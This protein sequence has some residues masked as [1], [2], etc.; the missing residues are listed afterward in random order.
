[1][2]RRFSSASDRQGFDHRNA[3]VSDTT[4]GT[5]VR[6]NNPGNWMDKDLQNTERRRN[7]LLE[8]VL[9][10][11]AESE[12]LPAENKALHYR[13]DTSPISRAALQQRK[14]ELTEELAQ[15]KETHAT[16]IGTLQDEKNNLHKKLDH[17]QKKHQ[18]AVRTINAHTTRS[19]TFQDEK[20]SLQKELAQA[21]EE[22][23]QAADSFIR[24]L[25]YQKEDFEKY[26]AQVKEDCRQAVNT[27][28]IQI[29]TLEKQHEGDIQELEV[30]AS[31]LSKLH[32]ALNEPQT[33]GKEEGRPTVEVAKLE[34]Q[35]ADAYNAHQL[36][37]QSYT[38][39]I[40]LLEEMNQ[41]LLDKATPLS[42]SDRKRPRPADITEVQEID[43]LARFS[44]SS[45][46]EVQALIPGSTTPV[47]QSQLPKE[48]VSEIKEWVTKLD[49]LGSKK[50]Q[51]T[52]LKPNHEDSGTCLVQQFKHNTC[53]WIEP[54][55]ACHECLISGSPCIVIKDNRP[56]LLPL[57]E[58]WGRN[59]SPSDP[60]YWIQ[61]TWP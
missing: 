6:N 19:N 46:V 11:D 39:R 51:F 21:R 47:P 22:Y 13:I 9:I 60:G 34:Q 15:A 17:V 24:L 41:F 53:N 16:H 10:Q 31:E 42:K 49:G 33:V 12:D 18:E 7:N 23:R 35:L 36:E 50:G 27:K 44:S 61:R 43:K 45:N 56:T 2:E 25:G 57:T 14:D 38:N 59:L 20:N 1:M 55:M 52:W 54:D 5:A 32:D 3:V 37:K 29:R 30:M 40:K 4:D 28:D 26:V 8:I 58:L 48:V